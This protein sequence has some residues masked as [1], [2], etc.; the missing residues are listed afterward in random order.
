[1]QPLSWPCRSYRR[2]AHEH[3]V[4][5]KI[6]QQLRRI[7]VLFSLDRAANAPDRIA[8]RERDVRKRRVNDAVILDEIPPS[9]IEPIFR[10]ALTVLARIAD[11]RRSAHEMHDAAGRHVPAFPS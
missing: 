10:P 4:A 2:S 3:A 8:E 1:M 6:A 5:Q 9:R 11:L 7:V